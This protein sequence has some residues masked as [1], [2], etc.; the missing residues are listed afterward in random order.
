MTSTITA[1]EPVIGLEVHAQLRTKSKLFCA[2]PNL[3]GGEPNRHVCPVCL[4]YPG[5]LPMT[6]ARAVELAVRIGLATLCR[7]NETSI[8]ARKNYFYPDLP[9]GYQITQFDRPICE[10]GRIRIEVSGQ[11]GREIHVRRIHLE[12][13]AGKMLHDN[14]FSDVPESTSLLD[15]NRA[16]VPL[17][18]I[19]TEPDLHSPDEAHAYL[20]KLRHLLLYT[21]VSEANLEEG[22]L[23]CD[24]NISIRPKGSA[25]LGT[26]VEVK[27]LNSLRFLRQAIS[28]EI[29]RQTRV[30]SSGGRLD[31]ETRLWDTARGVTSLMRSKEE[32]NDYRYFPE[33]DLPPLIVTKEQ[34]AEIAGALPELPE[35]RAE[36]FV[37]QFGLVRHEAALLALDRARAERFENE[38][39]ANASRRPEVLASP[40][41]LKDVLRAAAK[42]ETGPV[43]E[44]ESENSEGSPFPIPAAAVVE[45]A[46]LLASRAVTF[47]IA[48]RILFES[49]RSGKSPRK[50]VEDE[51]LSAVRDE[52]ILEAIIGRIVDG[53][54][55]QAEQYRSGKTAVLSFFV[56]QVMKETKGSA[57]GEL[58]RNLLKA[59]IEK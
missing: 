5:S 14:P 32:A 18:E 39:V 29:E 26:R 53:N 25:T 34:I 59:A 3:S 1:Y 13:D 49:A 21:E 45:T 7:I 19:V 42:L 16:G 30:L 23:R 4:G 41:T 27:N 43:L 36:R 55:K 46:L 54:P 52:K 11:E 28:Y 40:A 10:N 33:P 51:G 17:V 8:F 58:V 47:G 57:D 38:I 12:E 9:K 22:N 50:I 31:Q 44:F 37:N 56:G 20:T 24:A 15:F 48:K 2:C 35:S 6:N